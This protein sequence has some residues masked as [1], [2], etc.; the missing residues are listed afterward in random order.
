M[1]SQCR[2]CGGRCGESQPIELNRRGFLGQLAAGTAAWGLA[3][4]WASA[5]PLPAVVPLALPKAG[6]R[7]A[8]PLVPPRVYRGRNLEAVAMPLGGIGTGSVWLD[9]RGRLAVWQIFNNLSEPAIPDSFFAVSARREGGPAVTRVLQTT[10]EGPLAAVRSLDYEGGYPIARLTYRDPAL[11]VQVVLEAMNPLVPLDAANSSIPCALFRLTAKNPAPTAVDVTLA[12]T[13]QNAVGSGGARGIQ[14]VK[15]AQYGGNTNR[16]VR[17]DGLVAVAMGQSPDPMVSGAVK[18]RSGDGRE[19][20]CAEMFWLAGVPD[21]AAEAADCLARIAAQGGVVLAEGVSSRFFATLAALRSS[22]PDA[23]ATVFEDFEKKT[24]E[25]WTIKGN[26]FGNGPSH[27]TEPGQQPVTGFAGQ[28]LVNTFQ[29][30]DDPQGTATSRPFQIERRY[31]GFLIGGG[32]HPGETCI[33]LRVDGKVVRTATGKDREALEPASWDVADLAGR[34]AVIEIVDHSSQGWGHIN[35]DQIVFSDVPPESLLRRGTAGEA[36]ARALALAATAAEE[37]TLPAAARI[38]LAEHAPPALRSPAL[39][40]QWKVTRFTRLS[41]FQSGQHGYRI[42]A[43]TPEGDPLVVEGPLGK[44]RIILALAP[45]LP[46]SW[47]RE[48]L[49]SARGE[50]LRP[51]EQL[52]PGNPAWGSMALAAFDDRAV[53]LPEWSK[54][55]QLAA[56]LADPRPG[57]AGPPASSPAGETVNAALAVPLKLEG[58][59]SQSV[60][61]ALTWHF[62]NVQRFQHAGNLYSRRWPDATAVAGYLARNIEPLWER[63]RLYHQTLYQSNL[64]EEFLDAISSQS[65]I[66]RGPTCFWSEDGYFGGFEGSYG[67]CPLNCTHVWNYAQSHARLF[68]AVGQNMR[69]SNFITFLHAD[70][71]TSHREHA[72]H[73]A[74]IDGHCACIEAA[75]REYQL[76]PDRRLLEKIWPGVKKAVDWL[77]G[78]ID[79]E[80]QGLPHGPQWNTY[81]TAVSGANT[82]IGSQYLA[83]LAAG[84]RMA[85]AM[86]DPDSARRWQAVRRLGM[87]NQDEKLWNGQYYIQIPDRPGANDYNTG[88]HADQLLG[89]WW[90]HM[91][92]LGYLYPAPHVKAALAAVMKH[93]FHEKFALVKQSPRRYIPDDEG[94]LLICTWPRGG[95][96]KPFIMYADE[97]WTGIEYATAGAMLYEGLIDEARQIVGMARSR[98]DGRRREGLDSGP[99]GNPY[100]ELECGKFYARAMSSWS[101][102]IAA[103]GLVL[104]GPRGILG[105]RPNWQP[106]DHRSLF[107]A[108]EGWG[109]FVQHRTARQQTER[110][111]VRYGRLRLRELVFA[112]PGPAAG[113]TVTGAGRPVPAAL[114]Q[115]E[116]NVRLVLEQETEVP[117]GS[118][119]EVAFSLENPV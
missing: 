102:L 38:T 5:E 43:S 27:G 109:L 72:P 86:G 35:I 81:D 39:A 51:G 67:C 31:I 62:P 47:G 18:V 65:V 77:I 90:A 23:T 116:S 78:K 106:E 42:L 114:R 79:P 37:A 82:F 25:G 20:A 13:L 115:T 57:P 85:L 2:C 14:G 75:Y 118:A 17:Q 16:T 98:Y 29:G 83:A 107:T 46:W 93:N 99:G 68:P 34:Q 89:Q 1:S 101:L 41:G 52:Q 54:T 63:T 50:P 3:E 40:G 76:S 44:G 96:P 24:Y 61:F 74:F 6:P 69:I 94:G 92:D 30:G 95:R 32:N 28:G 108:P 53:A 26:A 59:Q 21:L 33:N 55:G 73:P 87:K 71:E 36:A 100:N 84:E 22:R 112:L 15:S 117:E 97:T 80:R 56:F 104:E 110:I 45:G 64:P 105:F 88:C 60:T 48:L 49:A 9:G 7:P 113:A 103:Q 91:L 19:S 70:G 119:L 8:Y 58:G 11:P 12:A 10:A 66:F 111:E 4:A